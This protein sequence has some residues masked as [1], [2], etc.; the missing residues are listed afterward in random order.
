MKE[1]IPNTTMIIGVR[2]VNIYRLQ[3]EL[4]QALVHTS[5]NLCG[6]WNKRIGHLHHKE[7]HVLREIVIGI[8]EFNIE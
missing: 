3:G 4:V 1:S 7:F 8:P 6:L 2:E 5:D